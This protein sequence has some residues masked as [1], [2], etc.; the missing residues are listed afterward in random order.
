MSEFWQDLARFTFLQYAVAAGLLASVASGVVGSY[1]VA[2][3]TTY[4]AGAISHCVLGGMGLARYLERVHGWTAATPMRG[5]VVAAVVA[6]LV[7]G[8][9]TLRGRQ[10][11]DTVLSAVW[12]VGMAL[13]VSFMVATPGYH[14]DL[15]SYLFGNILMVAGADLRLM[16][17]LNVAVL[18]LA[19][20]GH[21]ALVAIGFNERLARLRGVRVELYELL[22]LVVTA[23]TVVLLV[24]VVG[25][26]LAIALLTLPA[27]TAGFFTT[28]LPHMMLLATVLSMGLTLGGLALSYRPEW[29]AGATIVQLAGLVYLLAAG[30]Q[31]LRH[32]GRQTN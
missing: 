22:F 23:L 18:I 5:A 2:R 9:V 20:L 27:A 21:H 24:K 17:G 29:P 12:A 4:V 28:R 8:V 25:I 11:A 3:R 7:V 14:E 26:I 16:I 19:A 15:M 13:G 30:L 10:R 31:A 1:V 6:A 32:R